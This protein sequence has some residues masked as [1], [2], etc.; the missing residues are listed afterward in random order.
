M[1]RR[2]GRSAA[3]TPA[4]T[5]IAME[6]A[7]VIASTGATFSSERAGTLAQ[8]RYL[9]LLQW[10]ALQH[11]RR[12]GRLREQ[13]HDRVA[14]GEWQWPKRRGAH[15]R[16]HCGIGTEHQRKR[17]GACHEIRLAM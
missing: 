13:L 1:M 16:K 4:E 5:M 15:N 11:R 3:A 8:T 12:A 2:A 10:V 9:H 7:V 17:S 6:T 14:G